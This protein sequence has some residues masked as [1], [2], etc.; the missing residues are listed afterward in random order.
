VYRDVL[1]QI[2]FEVEQGI[3]QFI[4]QNTICYQDEIVDFLLTEYHICVYTESQVCRV[5]Q[6]LQQTHKRIERALFRSQMTEYNAKMG[7]F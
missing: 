1:R 6:R 2:H 3:L 5:L 4:E 7:A